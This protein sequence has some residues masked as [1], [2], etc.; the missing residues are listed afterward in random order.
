MS[1]HHEYVFDAVHTQGDEHPHDVTEE[2]ARKFIAEA[3]NGDS[4]NYFA[5][6]GAS[7]VR[8]DIQTIRT[9]FKSKEYDEKIR[10]LMKVFEE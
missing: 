3:Y 4:V 10:K 2:E 9:A 8:K 7:Y 5:K 1:I 6:E